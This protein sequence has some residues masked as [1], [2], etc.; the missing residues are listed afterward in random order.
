[1][2]NKLKLPMVLHKFSIGSQNADFLCLTLPQI[3]TP[4]R[5]KKRK[6]CLN[7]K[8]NLTRICTS[9][10]FDI[11]DS[12]LF[13]SQQWLQN[14]K[15]HGPLCLLGDKSIHLCSTN[16][17]Q[18]NF[19]KI[20]NEQLKAVL[21]KKENLYYESQSTLAKQLTHIGRF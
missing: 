2:F 15:K 19:I 20:T 18:Q 16:V 11:W 6:C 17:Q 14:I 10:L 4:Y 1:M 13:H 8:G 21:Q 12:S 3:L 7:F 5:Q 9:Y